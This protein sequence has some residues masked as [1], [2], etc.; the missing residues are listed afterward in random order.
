VIFCG[1]GYRNR[2][3][4]QQKSLSVCSRRA[5]ELDSHRINKKQTPELDL[6]VVS[7]IHGLRCAGCRLVY[8]LPKAPLKNVLAFQ[9]A[10]LSTSNASH[11]RHKPIPFMACQNEK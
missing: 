5:K 7:N 8:R 2:R 10:F 11:F 6:R 3:A 1:F 4:Y 9:G